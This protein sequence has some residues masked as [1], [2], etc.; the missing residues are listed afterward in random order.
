MWLDPVSYF[1]ILCHRNRHLIRSILQKFFDIDADGKRCFVKVLM[2]KF[3]AMEMDFETYTQFVQYLKNIDEFKDVLQN[4]LE[5]ELSQA[6]PMT[7]KNSLKNNS[8]ASTD[9]SRDFRCQTNGAVS[10]LLFVAV[11]ENNCNYL[12]LAFRSLAAKCHQRREHNSDWNQT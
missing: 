5:Q 3:G 11:R 9:S 10:L 8:T 6:N 4:G 12:F 1:N 2:R 7:T